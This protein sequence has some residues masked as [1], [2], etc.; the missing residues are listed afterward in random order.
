MPNDDKLDQVRD[1]VLIGAVLRSCWLATMTEVVFSVIYA[2]QNLFDI[3]VV[4]NK[5]GFVGHHV[6]KR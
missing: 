6:F 4:R 2:G 1:R 3:W 5:C